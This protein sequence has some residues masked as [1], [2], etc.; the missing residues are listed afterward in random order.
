MVNDLILATGILVVE[1]VVSDMVAADKYFSDLAIGKFQIL[2]P[3]KVNYSFM[4]TNDPGKS[5][6]KKRSHRVAPMMRAA[7]VSCR[8]TERIPATVL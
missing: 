4:D 5:T 2:P 1:V 6:L 7:L 8:S 3:V